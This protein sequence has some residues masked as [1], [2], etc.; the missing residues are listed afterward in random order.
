LGFSPLLLVT[1]IADPGILMTS[2][3]DPLLMR[4]LRSKTRNV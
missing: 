1:V 2:T 3:S 4:L